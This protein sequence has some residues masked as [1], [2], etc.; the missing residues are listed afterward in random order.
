MDPK[1]FVDEHLSPLLENVN[2]K[3][4]AFLVG[5]FNMD[6]MKT[7]ENVQTTE[8]FDAITS[9]QFVPHIIHPTRITPHSKTLIDNIF[10]NSPN[11]S[12]GVSGNIT[13]ALSDHLA[14]FLMIPLDTYIKPTK[15]EKF[16]RDTK[17]FDRENF[18]LDLLEI[19]WID[20][21]QLERQ[22]PN[23]SFNHFFQTIT[24]LIDKYMPLRKMTNKEIKHQ[25]KPWINRE[26]LKLIS[27]RDSLYRKFIKEKKGERKTE[28]ERQSKKKLFSCIL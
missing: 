1:E 24:S 23:L 19:D 16:I 21:I 25:T 20:T 8:Y 3:K 18:L 7:D 9:A 22:D 27:E 26:I 13:L 17:N 4:H 6:L 14:Q 5:D 11:F 12:Q 2:E 28:Y 15:E 10:S